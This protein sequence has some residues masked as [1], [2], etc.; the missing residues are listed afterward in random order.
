MIR[1]ILVRHGH[2][3]LNTPEGQ[4]QYFRGTT[5]LPLAEEGVAQAQATARRLSHLRIDAVYASP[6]QRAARTAQIV[7]KPHHL[8]AKTVPGLSSMSY[9]DWAGLLNT[10]VARRWPELYA[11]Y[12]SDP[13]SVQIPG[14]D[15][16]A[17]LR[18][19]ALRA[20]Q[21]I[22]ERHA[23]GACVVL[24]TH[25]AVCRTLVCA[26]GGLP[27]HGYWRI[28][29]GLC[30]LTV[31]DYHPANRTFALVEMNDACHLEPALPK[32]RGSGTRVVLI[33][34]G[35]TAW[36]AGAGEER[37]R[38]RT[39]LP[40]DSVGLG[41]AGALARRL[42]SEPIAALYAS[43][44]IR[45]SQTIEPLAGEL[46]LFIRSHGG[47]LDIHYGEFQ[48]LTHREA[49]AAYPEVYSQWRAA[50]SRVRF[51]GGESLV[52]VQERFVQLLGELVTAHP[53]ET[54]ALVGHQMVNK[55]AVCTLLEL[56]LDA[57]WLVQQDT[58]GI[59]VFQQVDGA[60]HTLQVND[61]CHLA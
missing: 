43:P 33:R 51:P 19:R 16:A 27:T 22:L 29:Q 45:A 20:V 40:L 30:N 9:G 34:H 39:D 31:F 41:Q 57:I 10:E 49:A 3:A 58:C 44:L 18:E 28:R 35:Q 56:T 14:G 61:T 23:D 25:E 52:D 46:G 47:L 38:G 37:F 24:V 55:V 36:N 54:V 11:Q 4:G 26:L 6:L 48:G 15:S 50:P 17:S 12:R 32:A 59:D 2:T 8:E 5:D 53:G 42:R 1:I 60:W 21:D 13:L 7:A